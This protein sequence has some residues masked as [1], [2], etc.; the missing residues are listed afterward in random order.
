MNCNKCNKPMDFKGEFPS[1]MPA[2]NPYP[3]EVW[4]CES[5]DLDLE[6]TRDSRW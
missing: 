5:C 4:R 3:I 1:D 6:W 2:A